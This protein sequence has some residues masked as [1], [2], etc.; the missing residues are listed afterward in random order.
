MVDSD[1]GFV[2][3]AK[4]LAG[5]FKERVGGLVLTKQSKL[6]TDGKVYLHGDKGPPLFKSLFKQL[7]REDQRYLSKL[8]PGD[9]V[10]FDD[11]KYGPELEAALKECLAGTSQH[12]KGAKVLPAEYDR[13]FFND[14][15]KTP[16]SKLKFIL[17]LRNKKTSLLYDTVEDQ[18][19]EI[20]YDI[21]R[22]RM[23]ALLGDGVSD[24]LATNSEDCLFAYRPGSTQRILTDHGRHAKVFNTWGEAPWRQD[25]SP[26]PE[27]TCPKE[28]QEFLELVFPDNKSRYYVEAWY[29]DA[30]FERAEPIM[31]LT[32]PPGTGKTISARNITS[33]LVGSKNYRSASRGFNK[34]YF[35]SGVTRCRVFFLDEMNLTL[36]S[37]ETLK[38]YHNG[39]ATIERKGID[40]GDPEKIYAS[41]ILANNIRNKINLEYTDRKFFVPTITDRPLIESWDREKIDNFCRLLNDDLDFIRQ[42]AS[43]IYFKYKAQETTK[44][45]KTDLFKDLCIRS[46]HP[47]IQAFAHGCKELQTIHGR[48]FS[49]GKRAV[50]DAFQLRDHLDLYQSQ[51]GENLADLKIHPDG[52]WVAT[53]LIYKPDPTKTNGS[54]YA[55]GS[56]GHV[57]D[58]LG[59][60]DTQT[61]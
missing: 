22:E 49:K 57:G 15:I 8:Y 59:A 56:G 16:I 25:W 55:N 37:R 12:Q 43:Y 21:I 35:H 10:D 20:D 34:S 47:F 32:G 51:F 4:Q 45:P 58:D 18:I 60:G 17:N 52:T 33:A 9:F 6:T 11:L 7:S 19:H 13:V 39:I 29:R 1:V 27:A 3:P 28:L 24:W 53:S 48:T 31:I 2:F 23:K 50:L 5:F 14:T 46:L 61:L 41:F 42:Y 26:D 30:T 40:V 54:G 36:D 44:F 38:D